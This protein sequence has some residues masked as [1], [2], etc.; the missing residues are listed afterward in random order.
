[1]ADDKHIRDY[2]LAYLE[3]LNALSEESKMSFVWTFKMRQA[4]DARGFGYVDIIPHPDS[5]RGED[6]K[7]I[8]IQKTMTQRQFNR[9]TTSAKDE[10][11]LGLI[12]DEGYDEETAETL[13]GSYNLKKLKDF[14]ELDLS[15][16]KEKVGSLKAWLNTLTKKG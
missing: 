11:M 16:S 7:V 2:S 5:K 4:L 10:L 13:I 8:K 3:E 12:K 1:M 6:G 9:F 14:N 15:Q